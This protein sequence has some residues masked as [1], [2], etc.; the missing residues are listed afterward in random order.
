M[1]SIRLALLLPLLT[2]TVAAPAQ[3]TA[4]P[5]AD[6]T[7][8][9]LTGDCGE[10]SAPAPKKPE[11]SKT[12]KLGKVERVETVRPPQLPQAPNP[13]RRKAPVSRQGEVAVSFAPGSIELA[14]SQLRLVD[15]IAKAFN[16]PATSG[17]RF[18]VEGHGSAG[19]SGDAI[20][21][22]TRRAEIVRRALIERGI[23]PD[24]I[25]T[26]GYGSSRPL[27]DVSPADSR[28][29]RVELRLIA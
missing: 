10:A 17:R 11:P 8:C 19:T 1:R 14:A 22:S 9:E 18:V 5:A 23:A 16:Q 21:L 24:R 2:A 27:P 26:K 25:E 4:P 28:N 3:V 20:R 15:Q 29:D 7:V 6:P 13:N 12:F